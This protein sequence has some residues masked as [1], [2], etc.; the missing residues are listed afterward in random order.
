[1][2][3]SQTII[4]LIV[5]LGP[6]NEGKSYL[7]CINTLKYTHFMISSNENFTSEL[8]SDENTHGDF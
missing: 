1:M 2:T 7:E 6:I 8:K 4:L 3:E 5:E